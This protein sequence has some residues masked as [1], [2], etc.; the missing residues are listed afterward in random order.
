[1]ATFVFARC[2]FR[3]AVK[4]PLLAAPCGT[5]CLCSLFDI[6]TIPIIAPRY[7]RLCST[8]KASSAVHQATA[9]RRTIPCQRLNLKYGRAPD[10]QSNAAKSETHGTVFRFSGPLT[11]RDMYSSLSPDTFRNIFESAPGDEPPA[12][13]TFDLNGVPYMDSIGL[14]MLASHYVRCQRKGIRLRITGVSPRAQELFRLTGMEKV[15]PIASNIEARVRLRQQTSRAW[16]VSF[17]VSSF[18]DC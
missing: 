1:M 16:E 6:S 17:S 18:P 3:K 12:A 13:H 5:I 11:T 14:G 2:F 10:S 4:R 8:Y 7:V 9:I 15:L